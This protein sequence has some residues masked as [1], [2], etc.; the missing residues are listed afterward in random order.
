M[1]QNQSEVDG[2]KSMPCIEMP[3]LTTDTS[4]QSLSF[5]SF[6]TGDERETDKPSENRPTVKALVSKYG[7]IEE[8]L[9]NAKSNNFNIKKKSFAA[10]CERLCTSYKD[11]VNM[12]GDTNRVEDVETFVRYYSRKSIMFTNKYIYFIFFVKP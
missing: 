4:D 6:S 2:A 11:C 7:L 9:R 12:E 3:A 10:A 8:K 1:S 5:K